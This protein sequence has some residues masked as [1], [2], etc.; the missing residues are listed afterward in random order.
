MAQATSPP[1]TRPEDE[2]QAPRYSSD[3]AGLG[4]ARAGAFAA[5][6]L[7]LIAVFL[8]FPALWV[9]YLGLTNYRLTGTAAAEPQFVGLD[10]LLD[11]VSNPT[12][13]S[14]TWLTVQ[15]V[16]GS[17]VIGQVG[18]GFAIA[19]LLRDRRGPLKRVV[20]GL[21]I[22]AWILP[23]A[24]VSFLWVAL[25]DRDG[26]TLNAL[27]GLPG[28]AWLLD[29]PMLSII[30]FNTWRGTAFSMMLYGAALGNV[31]PSHL[32][33]ARLAGASGW[34]Q[35]RDVVFPHIRGH[36]LTNLLLIS[37]WTFNDFSPFLLTAGGPDGKSEVLAV[38][39][40]KV[41][42]QSGELGYGAAVST[43]ILLINLVVAVFYL[44]LLRSKK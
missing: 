23:S 25:L 13:W 11:A 20:E 31:P 6:A 35:L 28:F 1:E 24:I 18:L 37:L 40:Y 7:L 9:L 44:R 39:V 41:A 12:F 8:V 14:S 19:W 34:Q 3:A 38:H 30:V 29:H 4:K 26:G 2:A 15:F 17:A 16:L 36:I 27:L 33:S 43:I 10:N 21:V 22:L 5:P 42:L 32:E